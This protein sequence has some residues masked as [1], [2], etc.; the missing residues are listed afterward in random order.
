MSSPRMMH[1]FTQTQLPN[2][3]KEELLNRTGYNITALETTSTFS[4]GTNVST[5]VFV[6]EFESSVEL[7]E[8]VTNVNEEITRSGISYEFVQ[9]VAVK[10]SGEVCSI[11]YYI[12]FH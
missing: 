2:F 1:I 6:V 3:T 10:P 5:I 7:K 12:E 11:F 9:L 4:N 8:N